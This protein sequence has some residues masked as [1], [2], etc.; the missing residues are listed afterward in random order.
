MPEIKRNHKCARKSK[1]SLCKKPIEDNI[2]YICHTRKSNH[3]SCYLSTPSGSYSKLPR[4]S[5]GLIGWNQLTD[6]I[7]KEKIQ[8]VLWPTMIFEEKRRCRLNIQ[9]ISKLTKNQIELALKQ[10]NVSHLPANCTK[11]DL[12]KRLEDYCTK[13]EN[14]NECKNARHLLVFGWFKEME[15]AT[16]TVMPIVL[17]ELI[18]S[19]R[20]F[21]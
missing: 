17:K 19:L 10:R 2:Y 11:S 1:C 15:H 5:E 8:R 9:N 6:M 12:C 13:H 16:N 20:P 18:Y 3:V 4:T 21:M 7:L 14:C